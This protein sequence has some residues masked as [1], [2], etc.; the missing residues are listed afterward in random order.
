MSNGRLYIVSTPI[1]NLEDFT[2]RAERVLRE[3]V[4]VAAEDTR[5]SRKLMDHFGISTPMLALH[6][7]NEE[8]LSPELVDRLLAGQDIA[9]ICDAGTPL[10]SDPG[11]V[12]VRA[13]RAAGIEVVPIPG[14]SAVLSALSISGLPTDRFVFEGFLPAKR[15]ARRDRLLALKSETRTVVI[16]ESSHRIADCAD[17]LAELYGSE[18]QVLIAREL[19]KMHEQSVLIAASE[20]PHWISEDANR[21]RGEFVLVI[22]GQTRQENSIDDAEAVLRILLAELSPAMASRLAA[23]ITGQSRKALYKHA[24]EIKPEEE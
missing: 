7:H 3:V 22:A 15:K 2:I 23:R 13:A 12:L 10:I 16:Y 14:A 19:T 18:R 9:L 6:E 17:D 5:H 11:F 8:Q 20:L 4:H 24:L 1:G 21:Q